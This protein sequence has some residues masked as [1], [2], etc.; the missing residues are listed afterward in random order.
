MDLKA[1][2]SE[3]CDYAFQR[4]LMELAQVSSQPNQSLIKEPSA[5]SRILLIRTISAAEVAAGGMQESTAQISEF[6]VQIM[7]FD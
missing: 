6:I 2:L 7:Y 1:L 4:D 3:N 5:M